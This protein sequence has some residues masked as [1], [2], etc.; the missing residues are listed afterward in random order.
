MPDFVRGT[1]CCDQSGV[2]DLACQRQFGLAAQLLQA[3]TFGGEISGL[4]LKQ[5]RREVPQYGFGLLTL[6]VELANAADQ[7]GQRI[8]V[9]DFGQALQRFDAILAI[10]SS[11]FQQRDVNELAARGLDQFLVGEAAKDVGRCAGALRQ[12]ES[13]AGLIISGCGCLN[14]EKCRH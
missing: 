12:N 9:V 5:Q 4:G 7:L 8:G 11:A 14:A 3:G 1:V 2:A 6:Q 10:E 13:F